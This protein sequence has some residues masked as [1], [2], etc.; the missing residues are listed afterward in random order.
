MTVDGNSEA[1]DVVVVV[2]EAG[3]DAVPRI[4]TVA[5]VVVVT[6]GDTEDVAEDTADAGLI[7]VKICVPGDCKVENVLVMGLTEVT[8]REDCAIDK[9]L[10]NTDAP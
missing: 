3:R 1:P 2:T 8:L 7:E 5:V 4:V 10:A 9:A 6:H